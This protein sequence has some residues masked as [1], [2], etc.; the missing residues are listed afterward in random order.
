MSL[1][2]IREFYNVPAKRGMSVLVQGK[3]GII[4]GARHQYLRIR[5]EGEKKIGSYHPTWEI[6]YLSQKGIK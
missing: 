4:V 3:K 6:E 5:I 1:N 2:Y